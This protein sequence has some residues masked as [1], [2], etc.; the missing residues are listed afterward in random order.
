MECHLL[1]ACEK[2]G[3]DK[4]F[5]AYQMGTAYVV[6][7]EGGCIGDSSR[8]T[9]KGKHHVHD[10]QECANI[11]GM[12]KKCM[13]FAVS[14]YQGVTNVGDGFSDSD[15]KDYKDQYYCHTLQYC[16]KNNNKDW[17]SYTIAYEDE[18]MEEANHHSHKGTGSPAS[19]Q[20][21]FKVDRMAVGGICLVAVV[22]MGALLYIQ[23]AK[24]DSEPL[25]AEHSAD[26]VKF[27]EEV[28]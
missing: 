5:T 16:N 6:H 7:N 4:S 19:S 3:P 20:Y 1:S 12:Q 10:V 9:P 22:A 13:Y 2:Y 27:N 24:Q 23:K 28:L 11:C 17:I 8:F 18:D 21:I 14:T 15:S 26:S 25:L